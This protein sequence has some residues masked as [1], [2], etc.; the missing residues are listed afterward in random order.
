MSHA[1][2]AELNRDSVGADQSTFQNRSRQCRLLL[3][4]NADR[5]LVSLCITERELNL[6]QLFTPDWRTTTG[7]QTQPKYIAEQEDLAK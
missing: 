2:V 3:L 7:R 6:V 1:E 4:R 5:N